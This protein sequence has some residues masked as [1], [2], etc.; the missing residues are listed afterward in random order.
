MP[1]AYE[2]SVDAKDGN[3]LVLTI[4]ETVQAVVE[5]YMQQNI[6]T[7]KVYNRGC[8]I[9]MDVTNGEII[10]VALTLTNLIQ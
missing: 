1:F 2:Q 10:A 3:N 7:N 9:M 5:K 8:A 4:D 6:I